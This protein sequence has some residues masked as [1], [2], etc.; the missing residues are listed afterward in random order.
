MTTAP[1][2]AAAR[3]A[4]S[5]AVPNEPIDQPPA[6]FRGIND[7]DAIRH[8]VLAEL[9]CLDT[10]GVWDLAVIGWTARCGPD[11]ALTIAS[12][13]AGAYRAGLDHAAG[14]H[15]RDGSCCGL[16]AGDV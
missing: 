10:L 16:P 13:I 8:A 6:V 15:V 5:A 14:E 4:A 2:V 9:A 12:L 3:L 11:Y 1:D 7:P